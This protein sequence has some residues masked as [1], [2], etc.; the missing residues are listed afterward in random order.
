MSS[1][2]ENQRA[3]SGSDRRFLPRS[4]PG[5]RSEDIK[6]SDLLPNVDVE[7]AAPRSTPVSYLFILFATLMIGVVGV[8]SLNSFFAPLLY[9]DRHVWSV[10]K[11]LSDGNSYLTYDL[12]IETRGLRRESIRSLPSRPEFVVMGASHWQE[13]HRAIVPGVD[14]YNAH[15]HRDYYEDIVA[16]ASWFYTFD[17]MPQK[18]MI[19]IRDNQFAPVA[20]RTDF[21]WVP[22]L[23]DYRR[24]AP[25]FGLE[26][27][28]EYANGLT[29]RLRQ[30]VSLPLLWDNVERFLNSPVLPSISSDVQ[31]ETLDVLLPD[32]GIYWSQKH[33]RSFTPERTYRE[34]IALAEAK[35]ESPP[36][37]DPVGLEA[38][39]RVIA[40][41]IDHGVEVS[42]SH[43]P[44]N[45]VVWDHVQGTRYIPAL[46]RI[47]DAVQAVA[48]NHGIRVVGSFNPYEV[49][50]TNDMYIDGEH[51]SPLCL[52]EIIAEALEPTDPK[53]ASAETGAGR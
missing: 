51:S 16:V 14:F 8:R 12:N 19:S 15:V 24:A 46:K 25:I 10:G 44:F 34:S 17:K 21:L 53:L 42:L 30:A 29:P 6:R 36:T 52:A 1:D 9:D 3:E 2:T 31:H 49:G 35:I 23:P 48:D 38:L 39:D 47:E 33:R 45:P 27:H 7:D 11:L 40:F 50:C 37:I 18:L 22:V 26:P 13:A 5:R 32:G 20:D 43:P 4:E 41:M 28:F